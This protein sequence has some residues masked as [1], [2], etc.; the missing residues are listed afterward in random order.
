MSLSQANARR[1][2]EC[3]GRGLKVLVYTVNAQKDLDR[4]ARM[5]V[6]GVFSNFPELSC[7]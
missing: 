3:H 7:P 1:V 5:G 4:L 6:D 2:R